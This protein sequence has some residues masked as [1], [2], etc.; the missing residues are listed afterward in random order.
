MVLQRTAGWRVPVTESAVTRTF[1]VGTYEV[2]ATIPR[3]R[4]GTVLH[5]TCEW[6]PC[7]PARLTDTELLQYDREMAALLAEALS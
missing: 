1:R 2:T 5:A 4:A 7:K 6:S 3:I